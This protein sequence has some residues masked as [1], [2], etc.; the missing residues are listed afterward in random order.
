MRRSFVCI[1]LGIAALL[2]PSAYAADVSQPTPQYASP[3]A[4]PPAPPPVFQPAPTEYKSPELQRRYVC[5]AGA[6]VEGVDSHPTFYNVPISGVD[7]ESF[8]DGPR[9]GVLGG[10][11]IVFASRTFLG[12]DTSAVF[13]AVRGSERPP[14]FQSGYDFNMPYEWD[15]RVR[16]G[17]M[18]DD[19]WS[20]YVAG[21]AEDA[22]RDTTSPAGVVHNG[23][24]WGG[25]VAVGVEW[26]FAQNWRLRG[27]YAFT[28]PGLSGL[29]FP[30][31]P[32]AQW[33]PSENL[34][35]LAIMR[36]FAF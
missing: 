14:G 15:S 29:S 21:G 11:D 23:F 32:Y 2:R 7:Q 10:C 1:A 16:L 28:W 24:D 26:Q 22:Y 8:A 13:G 3:P 6:I 31:S 18:L 17:Y 9:G 19:Q 5:Y 34:I 20:V 33:A 30:G 4:I 35:R 27:E 36:T 12:M 25:Q